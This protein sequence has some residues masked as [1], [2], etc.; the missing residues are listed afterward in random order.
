M[1]GKVIVATSEAEIPLLQTLYKRGRKNGLQGLKQLNREELFEHE[2]HV[3]GIRG[4][5]VPQTG[6]I[7]YKQVSAKYAKI[8]RLWVG[9]SKLATAVKNIKK[10]SS[11]SV[12]VTDQGDFE[13]KLVVNCAGL[14]SDKIAK[15]TDPTVNLKIHPVPR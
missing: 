6:I 9:K 10:T 13:T 2:P 3:N 7:D 12:V 4:I 1:C 11:G 5:F 8:S 15:L 14:Y